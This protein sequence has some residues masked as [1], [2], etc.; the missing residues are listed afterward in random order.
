M[1][2]ARELSTRACL[3]MISP[4]TSP[5][6]RSRKKPAAADQER[7]PEQDEELK[8]RHSRKSSKTFCAA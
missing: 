2:S 5:K 7:Q 6:P 8:R 3:R 1:T 4:M